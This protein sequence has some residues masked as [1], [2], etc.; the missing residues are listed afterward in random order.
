VYDLLPSFVLGFHGCD[1]AVAEAIFAGRSILRPS[2][3]DYDWLGHGVYFWENNPARAHAYAE[4]MRDRPR[5]RGQRVRQ[6]AVVGAVIDLGCCLNLLD[7]VMI[8]LVKEA[9]ED[10]VSIA[11]SADEE[12]PRNRG[13]HDLLQRFLDCAVLEHLHRSRT[14]ASESLP[15]FDTVRAVFI[16][17]KP[18]YPRAGFHEKSHI[19]I[20]VRTPAA[21]K[22]YFRVLS[23]ADLGS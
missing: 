14:M 23:D 17:G 11:A 2:E 16:E 8:G 4:Q 1:S 22:G 12:L 19:Q 15:P 9:Y 21:I 5:R 18:I 20:C 6:P 10:L 7:Q 3:N 13:G